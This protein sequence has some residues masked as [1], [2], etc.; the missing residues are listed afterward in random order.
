MLTPVT[1]ELRSTV[2]EPVPPEVVHGFADVNAPGPESIVKLIWVPSSAFVKPVPS[3]TSTC[4]VKVCVAPTRF[5][6]FGV[7]EIFA[8]TTFNG[9]HGPS[10]GL[11]SASPS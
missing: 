6:P 8:S 3:L 2:Q 9:S 5:T 4:A 7:I 11:Y 1:N 10:D